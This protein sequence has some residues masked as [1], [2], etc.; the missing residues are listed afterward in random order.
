MLGGIMRG[1]RSSSGRPILM[2]G[3]TAPRLRDAPTGSHI[4]RQSGFRKGFVINL[5]ILLHGVLTEKPLA[6]LAFGG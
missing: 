4:G 5:A 6:M 1:C 2:A 3:A